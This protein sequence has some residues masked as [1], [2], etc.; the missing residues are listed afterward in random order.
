MSVLKADNGV[1]R[2]PRYHE[3]D[4][5]R[6]C[7]GMHYENIAKLVTKLERTFESQGY[8]ND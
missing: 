5:H 1:E 6:E 4:F 8:A 7:A 3:F 2:S